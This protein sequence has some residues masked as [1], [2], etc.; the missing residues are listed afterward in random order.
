[1][2]SR[3][4]LIIIAIFLI[5]GLGVWWWW[6][7]SSAAP[8]KKELAKRLTPAISVASV[9]I[10]DIDAERIKLKSK[11]T[12]SNPLPVDINTNK[13]SYEI[14]IDSVRVIQDV[15]NKPISIRSSDS[16][17]IEL[18][19]ELLAKPMARVLKY[20]DDEKVDSADYTMKARFTVDVPIGGE[21]DFTMNLT[22]R[23]PALRV[24]KI[25]VKDVDLNA[26]R[27]KKEGVDMVV[28]VTNPNAFPIK[29]KDGAFSFTVEDD[30][31]MEGVLEKMVD[32]PAHG[33]EDVSIHAAVK[34]GSVLKTGWKMLT[35]KKDTRF[36]YTFRYKL[37]SEN[38]MLNN[39]NMVTNMQG[40]LDEL[41]SAVKQMK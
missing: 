37:M 9:N 14:F 38:G 28:Q 8:A 12:L 7:S 16:A 10:S 23:L 15:Y 41:L 21:R 2:Q 11:V 25:K 13:L 20:F 33:N 35:D 6:R 27:L 1:M 30:M 24:P 3:K 18:P 26:L 29:M 34:D 17:V 32:I 22:K 36:T 31:K 39:S 5:A 40:T 4:W 19:M